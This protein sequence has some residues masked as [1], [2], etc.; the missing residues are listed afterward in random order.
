MFASLSTD[1]TVRIWD[2][3]V[4]EA[5]KVFDPVAKTTSKFLNFY[6]YFFL[7]YEWSHA[8]QVLNNFVVS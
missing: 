3:R 4:N 1:K 5:V 6:K 7:K 8:D 2:T